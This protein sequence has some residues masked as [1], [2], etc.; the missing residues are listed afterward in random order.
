MTI[1]LIRTYAT[2]SELSV[3]PESLSSVFFLQHSTHSVMCPSHG[4]H[5]DNN[6]LSSCSF[7]S[8]AVELKGMSDSPKRHMSWK[9]CTRPYTGRYT[10]EIYQEVYQEVYQ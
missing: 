2:Y 6:Y 5:L 9:S 10:K 7:D 1:A 8:L 4:S 3:A